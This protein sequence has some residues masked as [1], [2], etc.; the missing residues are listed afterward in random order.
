MEHNPLLSRLNIFSNPNMTDYIFAIPL[1][2][3]ELCNGTLDIRAVNFQEFDFP[4]N[5]G[6]SVFHAFTWQDYAKIITCFITIAAVLVGN[7][8]VILAVAHNRSLRTTI[9][10]YLANLAVADILICAFCIWVHL[11]ND[12][13]EPIYI[14][15]PFWCK[16]NGFAQSKSN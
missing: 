5:D 8:A 11:I 9:N 14:L 4:R 6:D 16:F 13:T 12:L 10:V 7:A 3:N 2:L 15:G 1:G